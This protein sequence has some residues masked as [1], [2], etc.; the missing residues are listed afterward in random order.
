TRIFAVS[1]AEVYVG[2]HDGTLSRIDLTRNADRVRW[3]EAVHSEPI[4]AIVH[5]SNILYTA[6]EDG[7]AKRLNAQ[8]GATI[9]THTHTGAVQSIAVDVRGNV[10][11]ASADSTVA[12]LNPEGDVRY[13]FTHDAPFTHVRVNPNRQA[14]A[15]SEDGLIH[16]LS[17]DGD[18]MRVI[19]TEG[20]I[21]HFVIGSESIR[22]HAYVALSTGEVVRYDF[23]GDIVWRFLLHDTPL[24]GITLDASGRL[25][26]I[27]TDGMIH[28][29]DPKRVFTSLDAGAM[30]VANNSE[31]HVFVGLEDGTLVKLNAAAET[32]WTQTIHGAAITDIVI[33]P[34]GFIYTASADQHIA[35]LDENGV[36]DWM[37]SEHTDTVSAITIDAQ[38]HVY[39]ASAD[40]TV[41]KLNADGDT[42]WTYTGHDGAV[43][44]VTVNLDG[45]VI[46]AGADGTVRKLS[47]TGSNIWTFTDHDGPVNDVI[48]DSEGRIY[49]VSDDETFR[50]L[51]DNGREF[52][53]YSRFI[54]NPVNVIPVRTLTLDADDNIYIGTELSGS[55][56]PTVRRIDEATRVSIFHN[57]INTVQSD[58]F[59]RALVNTFII[60]FVSVPVSV[61]IAL[62]LSVW[63]NSIKKFQGFFQ[64]IFFLPYVTN[65]IAIGMAFAVIFNREFGLINFFLTEVFG[66]S[67]GLNWLGRVSVDENV[68]GIR[69]QLQLYLNLPMLSLMVFI[70][71]GSLA[72][73]IMVFLSGLQSIDKQY[74]D[75]AR[76]D[77]TPKSRVFRRITVPLLSPMIAYITITSFIGA[78][79]EYT[80]IVGMFGVNLG[81]PGDPDRLITIV[82]LVY[83]SLDEMGVPGRLSEAAATAIILFFMTLVLTLFNM[84]VSKK[85]V[86]Y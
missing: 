40:G 79:K 12:S 64:T 56:S 10:Y 78:F 3:T 18:V 24:Q 19:D 52:W 45:E 73:K 81:P 84:Y 68:T 34:D 57:F 6:S 7:T 47:S 66:F 37:N 54:N 43:N 59:V 33:G 35:K 46:T 39:S 69:R 27:G 20:S 8:D 42:L 77:S 55:V 14:Y 48:V 50:R 15:V 16:R 32:L 2:S 74:Y 44:G 53:L 1:P 61:L 36:V 25:Y 23:D 76:V 86:H 82:G 49:T 41:R 70:I 51:T 75:A 62:L 65:A 63:L 9:W 4:T 60:V 17:V 85:R 30:S 80:A 28:R 21:E 5:A 72:F 22:T 13:T 83:K 29:T 38:G 71:W 31:G 11:T 26:T 58:M 67:E